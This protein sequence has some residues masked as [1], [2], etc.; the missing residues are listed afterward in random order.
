MNAIQAV[1]DL[2]TDQNLYV[3]DLHFNKNDLTQAGECLRLKNGAIP[4]LT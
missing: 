2:N 1:Q 4:Q 3:C